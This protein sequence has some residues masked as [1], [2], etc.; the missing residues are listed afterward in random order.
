MM[1]QDRLASPVAYDGHV[2]FFCKDGAVVALKTGPELEEVA[3]STIS[4]TD[5]VYGVAA[6][7]GAWLVRTGR[8]LLRISAPPAAAGGSGS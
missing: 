2:L 1:T 4:V 5:I 6:V 7:D 8:S 3:E